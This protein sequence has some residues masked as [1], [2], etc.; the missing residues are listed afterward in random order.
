MGR[1]LVLI[2]LFTFIVILSAGYFGFLS[3]MEGPIV[4]LVFFTP[5]LILSI[6]YCQV[7]RQGNPP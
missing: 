3:F 4:V 1:K 5:L 2:S 7:M 6:S